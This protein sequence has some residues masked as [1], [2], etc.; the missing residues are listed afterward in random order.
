MK[1]ISRE[2]KVGQRN[3]MKHWAAPVNSDIKATVT[4][5]Y[6]S[7]AW[8]RTPLIPALGRQRQVDF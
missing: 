6:M 2:R 4:N 8:W 7:W 3:K 1:W 5:Y